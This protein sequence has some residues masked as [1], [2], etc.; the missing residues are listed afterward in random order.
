MEWLDP[1][2]GGIVG[3]DTAPLIYFIEKHPTY[4]GIV[5]PFFAAMTRGDFRV[6]TSMVTLLEVLVQP[7]R[8]RDRELAQQ[9][10]DILIDAE[11][12][13]AMPLSQE[14]AETAARLRAEHNLRAADAIQAATVIHAGASFLLTNDA[15]FLSLPEFS[16]LLLSKLATPDRTPDA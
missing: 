15:R 14:I 5:H 2:K 9:Y 4:W 10:R 6:V 16:V 3:L 7:L 8:R 1:L 12:L 13:T 11:G